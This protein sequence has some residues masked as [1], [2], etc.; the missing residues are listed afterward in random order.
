ML[1]QILVFITIISDSFFSLSQSVYPFIFCKMK[2][3]LCLARCTCFLFLQVFYKV[4]FSV[5]RLYPFYDR[6]L[7]LCRIV[8]DRFFLGFTPR[9]TEKD[10]S[11]SVSV[12]D[13]SVF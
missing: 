12:T 7:S 8:Y 9:L 4:P 2:M 5:D 10:F 3:D 6:R 1:I 11:C 13:M